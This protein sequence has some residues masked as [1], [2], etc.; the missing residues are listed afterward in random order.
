MGEATRRLFFAAWPDDELRREVAHETRQAT[1]ECGGRVIPAENLHITLAFLGSV[2]EARLAEAIACRQELSVARF[3]VV[4]G[5]LVWWRRQELLCLEPD[6]GAEKLGELAVRLQDCLRERGFQVE[7]RPFRAHM[8]LARDVR[9]PQ[10]FKPIRQL[11]WQVQDV[12]LV[13]SKTSAK[14][15]E[16]TLL[17]P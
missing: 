3:D 11:R 16:Y 17:R 1:R 10:E 4:L 7:R 2:P 8:T 5:A 15:S 13:E 12:E 9:R 6:S 14:G